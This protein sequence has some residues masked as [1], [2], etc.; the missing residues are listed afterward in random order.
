MTNRDDFYQQRDLR[1]AYYI[2]NTVVKPQPVQICWD[3]DIARSLAGQ[4]L[5]LA[6]S[7]QLARFCR[8]AGFSGPNAP[9]HIPAP[10]G[11]ISLHE[12]IVTGCSRIDP[13]GRWVI[14]EV[15]QAVYCLGVGRQSGRADIFLGAS[16]W[17]AYAVD[18][19]VDLPPLADGAGDV[20]G[21]SMA[22]CIGAA[23][24]FKVSL[25]L[26]QPLI[27]GTF[28]LW[29]FGRDNQAL[30]GPPLV[31]TDL[32]NVL[33]VGAGA[34][35]T[36]LVYWLN[37]LPVSGQWDIVDHD[38]VQLNN[39]NRGLLFTAEDAGWEDHLRQ[40]KASVLA[41]YLEH[42]QPHDCWFDEFEA[43]GRRWDIVLPLANER[44]VR[45]LLQASRPPL[46]IHATTSPN[47][48]TQLHRHRPGQDRCLSCRLPDTNLPPPACAAT[49]LSL[50]ELGQERPPDAALPFLSAAAGLLIAADLLRLGLGG[51]E[52]E[53]GNLFTLDWFGDMG[54]P[55]MRHERCQPDCSG[56]GNPA[57][58]HVLNR[59]TRW[60]SMD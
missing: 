39:T 36:A 46:M 40:K 51:Y 44:K 47:W 26:P 57:V 59:T 58:R 16:G 19:E 28:S 12:A 49:L 34:V 3:E 8:C 37:F 14:G 11:G 18:Q 52:L 13:C 2:K 45:G 42:A 4:V 23:N 20:L 7:N 24:A 35:A 48:Q 32:G 5:L 43:E 1:T 22:A 15:S 29:S 50:P 25:G 53:N 41:R 31:A 30:Q 17:L 21:A 56:W 54:R 9:L 10:L 60:Y 33:M 6:L 38:E 27:R 55:T